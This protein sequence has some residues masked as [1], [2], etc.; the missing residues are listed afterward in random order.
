[1]DRNRRQLLDPASSNVLEED[2]TISLAVTVI[3]IL[4]LFVVMVAH[5]FIDTSQI[6]RAFKRI[7]GG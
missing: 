2:H 5:M 4:V 6:V 1:M 7:S 3:L